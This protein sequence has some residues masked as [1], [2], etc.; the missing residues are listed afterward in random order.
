M[1]THEGHKIRIAARFVLGGL[2][3]DFL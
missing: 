2:N 3:L 1:L